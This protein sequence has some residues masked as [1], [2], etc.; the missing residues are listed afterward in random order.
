[1]FRKQILCFDPELN[2]DDSDLSR[3][4]FYIQVQNCEQKA[5]TEKEQF[6]FSELNIQEVFEK[7]VDM[8]VLG[9]DNET[10]KIVMRC[11]L[12]FDFGLFMKQWG[13]K[14]DIKINII[15]RMLDCIDSY[16]ISRSIFSQEKYVANRK[17]NHQR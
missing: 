13:N 6:R 15:N 8:K 4:E 10:V 3:H 9:T 17:Q 11:Q 7:T 12:I 2:N 14:I 16:R 1:M 5:I